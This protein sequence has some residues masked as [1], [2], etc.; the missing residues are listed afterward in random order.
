KPGAQQ[1]GSPYNAYRFN[2]D[3]F[4]GPG[5]YDMGFR[6]YSPGLNQ[7][8]TRDMFNSA[9]DDS[10]LDTDPFTG[11]RYTFGGGNPISNIELDGHC[12]SWL[13]GACNVVNGAVD[14]T[15]NDF[16]D[17]A[18][19]LI[20]NFLVAGA[21]IA[22]PSMAGPTGAEGCNQAAQQDI[23]PQVEQKTQIH[24]PLGGDPNSRGYHIGEFLG[25]WILPALPVFGGLVAIVRDV[26]Q[27][28]LRAAA[29][30]AARDAAAAAAR[31]A[32]RQAATSA[33]DRIAAS[34]AGD[35]GAARATWGSWNDYSKVTIGGRQYADI[36]GTLYSR[37]AVERMGPSGLGNA[38]GGVAGRSISPN[39]VQDVLD[40]PDSVTP[41]KGPNGE[42]RLS[43][44]S[45]SVQ[46]ITENGIVVT[47]IT[48]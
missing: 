22:C 7:F 32:A 2:A 27:A 31:A 39:F 4:D 10:G 36:N 46:V 41:V 18:R 6:D 9:L 12:W 16:L 37:H 5:G 21:G 13:Q 8:L 19:N 47:I 30:A 17:P 35:A 34:A 11:G 24:V 44:V 1:S 42:P 29:E 28:A 43:Y 15:V 3:R 14:V 20:S 45:G 23:P 40:N 25:R 26:V 48:R 33:G 38:A